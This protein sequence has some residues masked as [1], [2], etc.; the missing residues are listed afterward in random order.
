METLGGDKC[1]GK[2]QCPLS[3]GDTVQEQGLLSA[4]GM[5]LLMVRSHSVEM[6]PARKE[7]RALEAGRCFIGA[8][9]GNLNLAS[10]S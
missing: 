7:V 1:E 3:A 8:W 2:K 5:S 4:V 9:E 10:V 6:R